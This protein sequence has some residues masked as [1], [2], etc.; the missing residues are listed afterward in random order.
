MSKLSLG[1]NARSV[2]RFLVSA[3]SG[4]LLCGAAVADV[5]PNPLMMRYPAISDSQIAFAYA[6]SIWVAPRDGGMA[7]PV[8]AP[9]G[10]SVLPRFSPDGRTIA[11]VGN[12]DGNRDIYTIPV[13]GGIPNRVT[14]HPGAEA[15]CGWAGPDK[16]LFFT[17]GLAGNGRMTQLFTVPATGGMPEKLP[18]PYAAFG[19]LSA[20]GQMVVFTPHS[21]DNRTWK[22]YRGGMATDIWLL[23][24]KDQTSRRLTDWE[25]TDTLPMWG[26]GPAART[27]YYL[28]DNGPEHR[29]NIWSIDLDTGVREQVTK[30]ADDDVRWPSIGPSAAPPAGGNGRGSIVFQLGSRLM[31]LD[32]DSHQSKP[33]QITI[34]GARP[35]IRPQL[36]DASKN[37]SSFAISPGGKRVLLVGRGDLWSLPS[38]EGVVR[39]L[40]R[41]DGAFER[42]GAWSPD[43][44]YVAYFSDA[45]GEYEL[46][47]APSDARSPDAD[48]ADEKSKDGE[49]ADKADKK[50]APSSPP[51]PSAEGEKK[52]DDQADAKSESK[53]E[54]KAAKP[55]REPVRVTNL[56][57]GFRYNP[58]WSP[59]SKHIAF[60]DNAGS[61]IIATIKFDTDDGVPTAE[62]KVV[63]ADP[64]A[65]QLSGSWSHDSNWFAYARNDEGINSGAIWLYNMKTGEK[66]RVTSPMFSAGSPAFDRKGDFL[67]YRSAR[68]FTSPRYADGDTTFIY[69][70]TEQ[71]MMAPLRADVKSPLAVVSDEEEWKKDAKPSDAKGDAKGDA[72]KDKH[73]DEAKPAE[74]ADAKPADSKNGEA[75]ADAA[76]KPDAAKDEAKAKPSKDLKIDLAGFEDRASILPVTG[77]NFGALAVADDGKLV[78]ARLSA[79]GTQEKPSIKIFD[80]KDEAKEEKTVLAD[81]SDFV[82][83]AGGK[84]LLVS[85]GGGG[86]GGAK[87][88]IVDAAAGGGKAQ[89][90]STSGMRALISPRDE[91]KQIFADAWRLQR[92]FF[93]DPNMHGVDWNRIRT[94]YAAI[95]DDAANREDVQFIIGE[96]ISELNIG[97][98]YVQNPGDVD[99]GPSVNVG[100]LGCDFELVK[101][102]GGGGAD[103]P[104]YR[105]SR[106][107]DGGEWD[108][109]ARSPL[110]TSPDP[111]KRVKVGDYLLAVDG[112]PVD[113]SMDPWA[114]FIGLA[115]RPVTLTVND[116][117]SMTG[118]REVL[119]KTIGNEG[120]L[121]YRAWV[122][123]NRAYVDQKTGG[124]VGYIHVPD[125]GVNGQ[126]ELFRQFFGQRAREALII[127]ERWNGGGQIPTRFIEL[128][129]RPATNYW[130]RRHGVNWTWPPDGHRGPKC[131]LI[132]GLSGSG[133]DMFPWLF[134]HDQLGKVIGT[135]TWGGL[136]GISGNPEFIDGGS[137]TVPTFG[138]FKTDGTWGVEGH[139]VDPDIVVI[140]D[141]A[142]MLTTPD[143]SV[144]DPQLDASIDL[145]L[146]QIRT[147]PYT[148]PQRPAGPDRSGMGIPERDR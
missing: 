53:P 21:I 15:L 95:L 34:P 57:P 78:Y 1:G 74:G 102:D 56:G 61:L 126:N 25:G 79:R 12:Y 84:K 43:G 80:P 22:R 96:M 120:A 137:M 70:G 52:S 118:A 14:H 65:D 39:N 122:E 82:M 28:S 99:P 139:G 26:F 45:S 89:D 133:G 77:G 6:N 2:H 93:Y 40:T 124:K 86:G 140:D 27:V 87:F 58:M 134:K 91:W 20:D 76:K 107:V 103:K 81:A 48:K 42:D 47:L 46:W 51:S 143:G 106:I 121:R 66:T 85:R 18:M 10:Q 144:R 136:V 125:T 101:P 138:F 41:T 37:I 16:L 4:T 32:L 105:I 54:T 127:D 128:L 13:T 35:N 148:P 130:A 7:T 75:H 119:V 64:W 111:K 5:Q 31:V 92:D 98:A 90:V 113:P 123:R 104:A 49:G 55:L 44:R 110:S 129:N 30:F 132:N 8:A 63:D 145:M 38:K 60:T 135:R 109:D 83:A 67:Y 69:A 108:S 112:V 9:P 142:K 114:A 62:V 94:H 68:N 3:I 24:L 147:N 71:L 36:E 19:S 73:K 88:T 50:D 23:N 116:T 100:L 115:D 29:L 72:K 131:M 11:F 59:D 117:P 33:V 17:N 97:H 141:P 146:E